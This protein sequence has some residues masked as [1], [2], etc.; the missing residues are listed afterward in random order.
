[1]LEGVYPQQKIII[2][3]VK[4]TAFWIKIVIALIP[5]I[6]TIILAKIRKKK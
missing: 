3:T 1:M 4:G 6:G 2:E 5:V